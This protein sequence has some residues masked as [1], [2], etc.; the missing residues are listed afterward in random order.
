MAADEL[1]YAVWLAYLRVTRRIVGVRSTYQGRSASVRRREI[2]V[3][4]KQFRS[5][6]ISLPPPRVVRVVIGVDGDHDAGWSDL[7][8][9]F[10]H[11]VR[12]TGQRELLDEVLAAK[13]AACVSKRDERAL[14]GLSTPGELADM[15][16]VGH[17]RNKTRPSR[18]HGLVRHGGCRGGFKVVSPV[19][20]AVKRKPE[21]EVVRSFSPRTWDDTK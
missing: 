20:G 13:R 9:F 4:L 3:M 6:P 21:A 8:K 19:R 14:R 18:G 17:K 11:D 16:L 10:N 15:Y 5:R 2:L 7:G 12:M 1:S